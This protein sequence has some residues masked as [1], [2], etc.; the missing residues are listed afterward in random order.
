M[1]N[2]PAFPTNFLPPDQGMTLRDY[3][4]AKAMQALITSNRWEDEDIRATKNIPVNDFWSRTSYLA[5]RYAHAML[6]ER[7]HSNK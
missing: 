2:P 4:A 3:F 6:E 5:F 1:E 7:E